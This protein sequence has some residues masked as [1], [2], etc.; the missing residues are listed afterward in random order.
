M[1]TLRADLVLVAQQIP[2]GSRVLDLGCGSATLLSHLI[3]ERGCEGTGV[4]IDN[5]KV[6]RAIGRG[7]PIIELDVDH[8]LSEFGDQSYD[9]C[10][11][12]RTIQ[13]IERPEHVLAEMG[14]IAS[15]L[16]VS[17]PNFGWWGH[18]L[19]LLRGKMPMSKELPYRWY[20]TPN[21]RHTTL[22]DLER[23]FDSLH[24]TVQKRYTF[25]EDGRRLRMQGIWANLTAGAAV[26]VLRKS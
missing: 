4:E 2:D 12:S 21:I 17:V 1:S 20:N 9:V 3:N 5:E 26:Y 14:R 8:Q 7:V 6:L 24:Y 13:T 16:V 18:R 19:R 10:V 22:W 11:L 25:T 23:L 15:T